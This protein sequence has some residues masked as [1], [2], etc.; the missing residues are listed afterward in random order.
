MIP[1]RVF[2]SA[3][4]PRTCRASAIVLALSLFIPSQDLVAQASSSDQLIRESTANSSKDPYASGVVL[5]GIHKGLHSSGLAEQPMPRSLV[6]ETPG[7]PFPTDASITKPEVV[8]RVVEEGRLERWSIA[9]PA[10]QRNVSVQ[11]Y[12]AANPDE[13]APHLILLDGVSAR[14]NS[15]WVREGFV[16]PV[17]AEEN[18]TIIMPNE[19]TG[20]MYTDWQNDDPALGRMQ[21]ETFITEELAPLLAADESLNYNG[22]RGIGGLSMGAGAALRIANLH[23]MLFD[24]ALG[25]SGCYSS[26]DPLGSQTIKM[27]VESRGADTTNMWGPRGSEDWVR[28]DVVHNPTGLRDMAVYLSV[29]NG[30]IGKADHDVYATHPAD[31]MGKGVI[32]ERG[33]LTCTEDLEKSMVAAGMDHQIVDYSP[34]GAHNWSTYGPQLQ[35]GWEAVRDALSQG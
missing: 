35:P 28:N 12:R 6:E 27:T 4:V 33:A 2:S 29:A 20:S 5:G 21:W 7:Y 10:M 23:P 26:L 15:G 22:H 18:A 31:D 24:A 34:T 14:D 3:V 19:A 9:S 32:L 8:E 13:P 11:V 16:Q 17:F 30:V 25:F 1:I